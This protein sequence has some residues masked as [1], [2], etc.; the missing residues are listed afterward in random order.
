MRAWLSYVVEN[1]GG[2]SYFIENQI[3]TATLSVNFNFPDT[4]PELQYTFIEQSLTPG[5]QVSLRCS[6][7]GSPPPQFTWLLD[8]ELISE[9]PSS[10]RYAVSQYVDQSGDVISHLNI[11]SVRTEDGGLYICKAGNNLGTVTHQARLN[12]YG[13]YKFKSQRDRQ[14]LPSSTW[15]DPGKQLLLHE[16]SA[17]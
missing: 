14:R 1:V 10:H 8:G 6:A 15:C 4:V 5:P 16:H 9:M 7:S 2:G 11:S 13:N 3:T 17:I 12:V